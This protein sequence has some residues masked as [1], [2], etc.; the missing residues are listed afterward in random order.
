[1]AD[2]LLLVSVTEVAEWL[3]IPVPSLD[4]RQTNILTRS[5]TSAQN[6]V[7]AHLN[8]RLV[9]ENHT[10][11]ELYWDSRYEQTDTRAWPEAA[12]YFTDDYTPVTAVTSATDPAAYDV[13]FKVGL[14]VA[15]DPDCGIIL[16]FIL[17]DTLEA[18]INSPFI[19]EVRRQI[20]S[21]SA[22]GQSVTYEARPTTPAAAGG[23]LTLDSLIRFRRYAVGHGAATDQRPFP[24]RA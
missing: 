12:P 15:G 2:P 18:L 23:A 16:D 4:N 9:A 19:A 5:I 7:A 13:T 8:R 21:V 6:K 14:D 1:M 11:T 20:K 17:Q 24:Y 3:D 22:E 10:L